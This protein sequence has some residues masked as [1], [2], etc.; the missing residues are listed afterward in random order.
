MNALLRLEALLF[1]EVWI[2]LQHGNVLCNPLCQRLDRNYGISLFK[3]DMVWVIA[4][5]LSAYWLRE[6]LSMSLCYN[7]VSTFTKQLILISSGY[8]AFKI[9]NVNIDAW[10]KWSPKLGILRLLLDYWHFDTVV[11][12]II[13]FKR[14]FLQGFDTA[15][16]GCII[17]DIVH[18]DVTEENMNVLFPSKSALVLGA[19]VIWFIHALVVQISRKSTATMMV[20]LYRKIAIFLGLVE[21]SKNDSVDS[22]QLPSMRESK[23]RHTNDKTKGTN[24]D[25][26]LGPHIHTIHKSSHDCL[27]CRMLAKPDQN[28]KS[29]KLTSP[30]VVFL[31]HPMQLSSA[32]SLW[33][34]KGSNKETYWRASW[35]M[36]NIVAQSIVFFISIVVYP[37]GTLCFRCSPVVIVDKSS[38]LF[39]KAAPPS[40]TESENDILLPSIITR[41]EVWF[42]KSFG[43]Q[44]ITASP[45]WQGYAKETVVRSALRAQNQGVKVLGLG[46]LNKAHWLNNGGEDLV[47][48]LERRSPEGYILSPLDVELGLLKPET[49]M[50]KIKIV[51]GNTLTAAVVCYQLRVLLGE[52]FANQ[53]PPH[54]DCIEPLQA[55]TVIIIGATSKIGRAVALT[56]AATEHVRVICVGCKSKR[57]DSII[58]EGRVAALSTGTG[59]EII[60]CTDVLA[61][62][63]SAVDAVWL[64]GK[65]DRSSPLADIIP[66]GSRVLSYAVP[67]PLSVLEGQG[68]CEKKRSGV[69]RPLLRDD[70]RYL[71]AGVMVLP[72][73]MQAQRQFA[74]M[75][76]NHL[77]YTCHAAA[78]VH[79]LEGWEHHEVGEV[80]LEN[81]DVTLTAAVRHGFSVSLMSPR[82]SNG[83]H[84]RYGQSDGQR[85]GRMADVAVIGCGPGGLATAASLLSTGTNTT[86]SS[87]AHFMRGSTPVLGG[88]I[89]NT[90]GDA[91]P[92]VV[93]FDHHTDIEGQVWKTPPRSSLIV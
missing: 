33:S 10:R 13:S 58:E 59:S 75:L 11:N 19:A 26:F 78:L 88:K 66:L 52:H 51:H 64:L 17:Y 72:E 25:F 76:P 15:V 20:E 45:F 4:F 69:G 86:T 91:G 41:S 23:F 14:M 36:E 60:S 3:N 31:A 57:L 1:H 35:W 65:G 74:L 70:V 29:V 8:H 28:A 40:N 53:S 83:K 47:T 77:V 30:D 38:H 71:D 54:R 12:C 44:Y 79:H 42:A 6:I 81:M 80:S 67:C 43:W 73:A 87:S 61:A 21:P 90:R 27:V 48:D 39:Q 7:L 93:M 56:M 5:T 82:E 24:L 34:D 46:A 18:S 49:S 84:A 55:L 22:V 2:C 63:E 68:V 50:N 32:F 37:I 9:V 16:H 62:S 89:S 92:P 85:D